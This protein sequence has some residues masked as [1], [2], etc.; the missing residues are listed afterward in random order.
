MQAAPWIQDEYVMVVYGD[1]IHHPKIYQEMIALHHQTHKG[2]MLGKQV[3]REDISKYGILDIQDGHIVNILEKPSPSEAPSNYALFT[4][5]I[6]PRRVLDLLAS[7]APHPETGEIYPR[8]AVKSIM[9]Q[10]GI[11]LYESPHPMRDAS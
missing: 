6:W 3:A 2:V 11:L 1:E 7:S 4:P 5:F 10:E 8:D 9:D